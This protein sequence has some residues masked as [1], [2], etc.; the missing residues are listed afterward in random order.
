MFVDAPDYVY[1]FGL[2]VVADQVIHDFTVGGPGYLG[3]N[4]GFDVNVRGK[5]EFLVQVKRREVVD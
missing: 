3:W 4:R 1:G 2:G 5:Q